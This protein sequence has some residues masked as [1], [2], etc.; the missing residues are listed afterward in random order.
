MRELSI[1]SKCFTKVIVIDEPS[2][3]NNACHEYRIETVTKDQDGP[4]PVAIVAQV[5]FQDGPIKEAGVNGCHH[6]DLLAIVIHRLQSFQA[7]EYRCR[8]NALAL[9]KIE[10]AIHWL[11]HRTNER[12]KRG[13]EGTNAK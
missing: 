9:T 1:G 5:S 12:V 6:E 8:E 3:Q 11:N 4:Q 10:E 13:V 2:L 7:G